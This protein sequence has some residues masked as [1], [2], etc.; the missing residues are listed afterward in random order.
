VVARQAAREDYNRYGALLT[1]LIPATLASRYYTR[2]LGQ[3]SN[4][5]TN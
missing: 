2:W 5:L 4:Y 1:R 3:I